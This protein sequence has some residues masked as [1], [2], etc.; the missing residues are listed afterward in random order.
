MSIFDYLR[1]KRAPSTASV[2][3]ERLQIIVAHERNKRNQPDY[4]PQMQQE[5]IDVIRKYININSDQV[6]V[7]LDDSENCSVLELNIT[8][9][10]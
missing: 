5:I 6:A 1:K 2:A 9:P 3:K 10:E 7:K 4:L 8:L